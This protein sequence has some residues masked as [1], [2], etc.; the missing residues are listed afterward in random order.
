MKRTGFSRKTYTPPPAAPLRA[1]TRPVNYGVTDDRANCRPKEEKSKPGKLSPN[2]AER[3]WMDWIVAYGCI[4]CRIDGNG[5]AEPCVH[6]LIRGGQRM[7]H[8]YTLP[9]CPGHHQDGAGVPGLIA[10]H[11]YKARFESKYGSEYSLLAAL[12]SEYEAGK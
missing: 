10:R 12:K 5:I 11:P 7:G 9:L 2:K 6:H 1:L 4:A 8:L 3:E